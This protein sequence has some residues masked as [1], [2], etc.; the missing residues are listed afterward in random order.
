MKKLIPLLLAAIFL[1]SCNWFKKP[2]PEPEYTRTVLVY[3]V[4][5]NNLYNF[6]IE[7]IKEMESVWNDDFNGKLLVF[8]NPRGLTLPSRLYE[9]K[10]SKGGAGVESKVIKEYGVRVNACDP[11]VLADVIADS[12]ALAPADSYGLVLWSHGTGW[13]PNGVRPLKSAPVRDGSVSYSFGSNETYKDEM[14]IWDLERALPRDFKFDFIAFDACYMASVESHYQLRNRAH[15]ILASPAETLAYGFPY[16][17][18][19]PLMFDRQV[20][21][22]TM[23]INIFEYYNKRVGSER[24]STISV[25]DCSKLEAVAASMKSLL[26]GVKDTP[27]LPNNIQQFGARKNGFYDVFYDLEDFVAKTYA[28]SPVLASFKSKLSDAVIYTAHT[29]WLYAFWKDSEMECRTSCGLTTY[30]PRKSQPITLEKYRTKFDW[31]RDSGMDK[32][33]F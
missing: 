26:A 32:I 31:S 14:E 19:V 5:D 16:D 15:F 22:R 6:A 20:D 3:M 23:G 17:R 24:H 13:L 8:L 2:D 10:R 21:M 28:D 27:V 30:I 9:V 1:S 18:I 4:A 29:P 25:V 11:A 12:R 33:E 7:D